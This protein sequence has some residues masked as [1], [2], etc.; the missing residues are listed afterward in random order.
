MWEFFVIVGSILVAFGLEAWWNGRIEADQARA[1]LETL[2]SEFSTTQERLVDLRLQLETV[3]VS[4]AALLPHI[5]P[6]AP[7][8]PVDSLNT[9]IDLS[10]RLGTVEMRLGSVQALLASG[11]LS[12]IP[13]PE[14]KALLAAWPADVSVLRRRSGLLEENRE[15]IID[16]LHDR[17]PTLDITHET[18]QMNRYP[19]SD[20]SAGADAVQRDMRV[21]GLFANR[22][23]MIEDADGVVVTLAE[24]ARRIRSIIE[25]LLG[26]R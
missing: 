8:L 9:M 5:S 11:E 10:F 24:E 22:G 3:R 7:L 2:H 12:R 1:Q 16:Y 19:R 26:A 6:D 23:M 18:G 25:E 13:D 15:I 20:F 4:V 17:I 21:E 14:L